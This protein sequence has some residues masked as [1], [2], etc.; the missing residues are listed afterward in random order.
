MTTERVYA[1]W[2][3]YDGVRSG[4]A[5]FGGTPH[6]FEQEWSAER[7]DYLSTFVLRSISSAALAQVVEQWKIF[8]TWELS[9]HRGEVEQG[10]HPALPGRN[11]RYAELDAVL[12]AILEA[13]GASPKSAIGKFSPT[14]DKSSIPKGAMYELQVEW[15]HAA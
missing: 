15:Q 2:E 5:D 4:V 11:A 14:P 7:Q 6:F 9:F 1:V 8:R 3:Y 13:P 12:K 10:S